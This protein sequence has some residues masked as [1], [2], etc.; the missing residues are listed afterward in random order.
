MLN[1]IFIQFVESSRVLSFN[2]FKFE[3]HLPPCS[4]SDEMDLNINEEEFVRS[5]DGTL[6]TINS[7]EPKQSLRSKNLLKVEN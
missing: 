5:T 4:S 1:S 7:T 6:L 2:M 3:F